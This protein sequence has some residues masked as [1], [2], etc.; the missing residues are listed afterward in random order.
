MGDKDFLCLLR[1]A[2]RCDQVVHVVALAEH[3]RLVGATEARDRLKQRVEHRL[4]LYGRAADSLEHVRGS[5]LLLKGLAQLL[6]AL[7][8]FP[9][10]P[11][12]LRSM[13]C[14][15]WTYSHADP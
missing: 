8:Q 14:G 12:V 9:E 1:K 5:G 2:V 11:R 6:G 7:T 13:L 10:K 3:I 4:E 15:S